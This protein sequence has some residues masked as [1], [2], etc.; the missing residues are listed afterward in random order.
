MRGW[1]M[2][3]NPSRLWLQRWAG[4]LQSYGSTNTTTPAQH[5][6]PKPALQPPSHTSS[7]P[8]L[9]NSLRAP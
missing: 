4:Y 6:V 3:S 9:H 1:K 5:A 2:F 8:C 7:S